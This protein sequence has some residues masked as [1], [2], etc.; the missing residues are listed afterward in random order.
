MPML[1]NIAELVQAQGHLVLATCAPGGR[2][3]QPHASLMAYCPSPDGG[4]FWLATLKETRK[5]ANLRANPRASLLL[6]DRV[7]DRVGDRGGQ[8]GGAPGQALTVDVELAAFADAQAEASA[9]RALLARH[10]EL[11]DFMALPGAVV[12]R[13]V[14]LR[15][16]L[17]HGLTEVFVWSPQKNLDGAGRTA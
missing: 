11:A 15:Y 5:Y 9:R 12:L 4:E 17:L 7:G 6:D 13:L 3:G 2:G 16:Q 8:G 10:P 14:G 1:K